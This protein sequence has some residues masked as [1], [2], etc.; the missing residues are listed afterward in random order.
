MGSAVR[1]SAELF[2]GSAARLS[3]SPR[4]SAAHFLAELFTGSVARLSD[5]LLVGSSVRLFVEPPS[6]SLQRAS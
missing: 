2:T 4:G 6:R 1:L 3:A 5:E